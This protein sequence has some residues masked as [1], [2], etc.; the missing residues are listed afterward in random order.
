M[1]Q[2]DK[3]HF[4]EL[5]DRVNQVPFNNLF[6]HA[7]IENKVSGKVYVLRLLTIVS[8]KTTNRFGPA[9]RRILGH[10]N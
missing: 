6:A 1:E 10:T 7:V 5:T 8:K 4:L 9:G 3:K 2:L